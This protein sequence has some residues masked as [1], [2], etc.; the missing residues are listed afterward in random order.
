MRIDKILSLCVFLFIFIIETGCSIL[1]P[2]SNN[3]RKKIDVIG[4]SIEVTS[5]WYKLTDKEINAYKSVCDFCE[6]DK[7][8]FELHVHVSSKDSTRKM[9]PFIL[10]VEFKKEEKYQQKISLTSKNHYQSKHGFSTKNNKR[11]RYEI[12]IKSF[13]I[14]SKKD[15]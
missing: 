5:F 3:Y 2:S 12:F 7:E 1:K 4:D 8:S 13:D 10:E 11:S 6:F 9:L 15:L 14:I